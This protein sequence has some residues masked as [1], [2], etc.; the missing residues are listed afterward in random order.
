MVRD[1]V[2]RER[3]ALDGLAVEDISQAAFVHRVAAF[4]AAQVMM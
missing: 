3:L 2:W 1:H 4:D